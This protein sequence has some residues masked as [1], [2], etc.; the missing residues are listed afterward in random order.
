[1]KSLLI[2]AMLVVGASSAM[3][4]ASDSETAGTYVKDSVITTKVKTKLAAKLHVDPGAYQGRTPMHRMARCGSA[5]K[6]L[7]PRMPRIWRNRSPRT[8]MVSPPFTIRSWWRR[9][10]RVDVSNGNAA[11]RAAFLFRPRS[12]ERAACADAQSEQQ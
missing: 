7:R 11:C 5:S 1:M 4:Y 9:S 6:A 3:V 8:P 12:T 10:F 2:S